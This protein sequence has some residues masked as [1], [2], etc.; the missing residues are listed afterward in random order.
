MLLK[1]LAFGGGSRGR[2]Y[3]EGFFQSCVNPTQIS[4]SA[5]VTVA[6]LFRNPEASIYMVELYYRICGGNFN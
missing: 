1:F 4:S 5:S 6:W 2:W 3:L